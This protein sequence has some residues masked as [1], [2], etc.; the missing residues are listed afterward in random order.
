MSPAWVGKFSK[1]IIFPKL[2]T[3]LL[4]LAL[5]GFSTRG[6]AQ[7]S[8]VI[9][10]GDN[11]FGQTNIPSGLSSVVAIS[12]GE[13]HNIA[14]KADGTVVAW[15][16]DNAGQG[17][18][19][20]DLNNVV[21]IAAGGYHNLAL[22]TDGTVRAWGANDYGQSVVP[23]GLKDVVAIAGGWVHSLALK[24]D[25]TVVAWG[26]NLEGQ[27][28]VPYGLNNVVAISAGEYHNLALKAD[29]TVTGWGWNGYGQAN[30]SGP[31]LSNNIIAIAACGLHSLVLKND[32]TVTAWGWNK[33]GQATVPAGLKNVVAITGGAEHSLALKSDGRVVGWGSNTA[34]AENNPDCAN[35]GNS[36]PRKYSG[37]IDVP[38]NVSNVVAI[39]AGVFHSVALKT[40]R[41]VLLTKTVTPAGSG[42]IITVP[43]SRNSQYIS[44]ATVTLIASPNYGYKF[45]HWSGASTA[46][47][48]RISLRMTGNKSITAVF[49]NWPWY[50][51]SASVNPS[52]SGLISASPYDASNLYPS[53]TL[54][55]LT[56]TPNSTNKFATWSGAVS[57]TSNKVS[58]TMNGNKS[59]VALFNKPQLLFQNTDGQVAIWVMQNTQRLSSAVL[60]NGAGFGSNWRLAA[61]AD[62]NGNGHKDLLF[63]GTNGQSKTWL[64]NGNMITGSSLLRSGFAMPASWRLVAS[65]DFN[66]DGKSDI[67]WQ[68]TSGTMNVWLMNGLTYTT[69]RTIT[70][71]AP[72]GWKTV[73]AADF[74]TN[75][76]ADL[77]LQ[78]A[79]GQL[80][81]WLMNGLTRTAVTNVNNGIS[82]GTSWLVS[83]IT[84]LN[85]DHRPDI[86]FQRTDGSLLV[87][88]LNGVSL[89]RASTLNT[90]APLWQLKAAK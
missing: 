33:Y 88:Y 48:S 76:V 26:R 84:D 39:A 63:Q 24:A 79:S 1:P 60:N 67:L 61:A 78:S 70:P 52:G 11:R 18:V 69:N 59:V 21:A 85:A 77:L 57:S 71:A 15:G 36:C 25:G 75:N 20:S 50:K 87:W 80:Q 41:M 90:A 49:T 45:L 82:P 37:Q 19:P 32:G 4:G 38:A 14:L 17:T 35:I 6:W 46:T 10:W 7:N 47:T 31:G 16:V 86:L 51:L 23:A 12:S 5:L 29:G 9:A 58:L 42:K 81:V 3:F 53:G 22:K 8:A 30:T 73:G 64:L 62:F 66:R 28:T 13:W 68:N 54:V 55:S 44:N 89:T 27:A 34:W 56:V 65:A 2:E 83:A 74:N 72:T 43:R 40:D